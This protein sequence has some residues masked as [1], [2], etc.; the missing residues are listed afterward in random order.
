M[1]TRLFPPAVRWT[2]AMNAPV[3][4]RIPDRD[5]NDPSELVAGCPHR[6]GPGVGS[7]E[8]RLQHKLE[9]DAAAHPGNCTH[10]VDPLGREQQPFRDRYQRLFSST[11]LQA[12]F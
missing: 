4:T 10:E 11:C 7:A 2:T 8:S 12:K 6:G 1:Y 3:T 5:P 9:E